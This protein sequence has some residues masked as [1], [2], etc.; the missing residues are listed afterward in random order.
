VSLSQDV[1]DEAEHRRLLQLQHVLVKATGRADSTTHTAK[2]RAFH[3]MRLF[4]SNRH[5]SSALERLRREHT[6]EIA[7]LRAEHSKAI[8]LLTEQHERHAATARLECDQ[9]ALRSAQLETQLT[10]ARTELEAERDKCNVLKLTVTDLKHTYT[11]Q[12]ERDQ[13]SIQDLELALQTAK[14]A[15]L[16]LQEMQDLRLR[17]LESALS[18]SSGTIEKL[19]VELSLTKEQV[20]VTESRTA[21]L[22]TSLGALQY[23]KS[24][25]CAKCLALEQ[26]V[27]STKSDISAQLEATKEQNAA[28]VA[29]LA[30]KASELAHLQQEHGAAQKHTEK[31]EARLRQL[32]A[33]FETSKG[34]LT[35]L[36]GEHAALRESEA[37]K[38]SALQSM[39]NN[40][41]NMNKLLEM[42][43]QNCE[44][45]VDYN[46]Q[47]DS[48]R[49]ERA[50]DLRV[51]EKVR[52]V[53]R[54]T[55]EQLS[56][57]QQERD[58]SA[59]RATQ[60]ADK[61]SELQNKLDA[62]QGRYRQLELHAQAESAR[63]ELQT[64]LLLSGEEATP[65]QVAA[66]TGVG[67]TS[68]HS[69]PATGSP[70]KASAAPSA[71]SPGQGSPTGGAVS[72]V[73]NSA[74]VVDAE[75]TPVGKLHD[76]VAKL[77][78]A[79]QKRDSQL[80]EVEE[81][82]HAL[83]ERFQEQ[84][85]EYKECMRGYADLEK[86]HNHAR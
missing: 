27:S 1:I 83:R 35:K 72:P 75:I 82:L 71:G 79:L 54:Q 67:A 21:S 49:K 32:H 36:E 18:Q 15:E 73:K 39:A 77:Q 59:L 53:L 86:R 19:R 55:K 62:L 16:R 5:H 68:V 20:T 8:Q 31:V 84:A 51:C 29:E 33:L 69:G 66:L 85:A 25:L 37:K 30:E 43:N 46:K 80:Q 41:Q 76:K 64:K 28:L 63:L 6:E 48:Q 60:Q 81:E 34:A 3:R 40:L 74:P 78:A 45:C 22:Q 42:R 61:A 56:Q 7:H 4:G 26:Q 47:L 70:V 17:E 9:A 12:Q 50:E 44:K 38:T 10:A 52:E 2:L 24:E 58:A 14:S 23:E 65:A 57:A 13:R 11:S